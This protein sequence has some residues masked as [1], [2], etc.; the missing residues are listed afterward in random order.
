[1]ANFFSG[2]ALWHDQNLWLSDCQEL[3][4]IDIADNLCYA[5]HEFIVEIF[6]K[7]FFYFDQVIDK[8]DREKT[9]IYPKN[10]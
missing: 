10:F 6:I 8:D 2:Q 9:F 4:D 5:K 1:M 3:W 7:I